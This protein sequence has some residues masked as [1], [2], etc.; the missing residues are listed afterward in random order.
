MAVTVEA[1]RVEFEYEGCPTCGRGKLWIT[2]GSDGF[3]GMSFQR[4][5]VVRSFV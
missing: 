3:R 2:V 5:F 4:V 1:Y